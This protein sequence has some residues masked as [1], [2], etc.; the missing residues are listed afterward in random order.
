MCKIL[1]FEQVSNALKR[2]D[3]DEGISIN[4]MDSLGREQ[5][6][7]VINESGLYSLIL[8]SKKPEAKVFKK[9]ITSE[10][11]PQFGKTSFECRKTFTSTI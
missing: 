9:W 11:L 7:N 10:V 5:R 8:G 3:A 2:L 4:L 6:T 1:D